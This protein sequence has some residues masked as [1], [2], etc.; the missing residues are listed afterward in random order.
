MVQPALCKSGTKFN[1]HEPLSLWCSGQLLCVPLSRTRSSITVNRFVCHFLGCT[2]S[3]VREKLHEGTRFPERS[4]PSSIPP[5]WRSSPNFGRSIAGSCIC[6]TI[7]SC[8]DFTLNC[9]TPSSRLGNAYL[10]GPVV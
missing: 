1:L 10:Y 9:M 6:L 8:S 5:H 4:S 2:P 7:C 3:R